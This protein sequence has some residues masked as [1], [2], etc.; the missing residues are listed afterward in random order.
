MTSRI[1]I[2]LAGKIGQSNWREEIVYGLQDQFTADYYSVHDMQEWPILPYGV[3]GTHDYTGPYFVSDSHHP[4]EDHGWVGEPGVPRYNPE[5]EALGA[6]GLTQIDRLQ[7]ADLCK[8]AIL[9]SDMVFAWIDSP[10]AYGTLVEIGFAV[11]AGIHTAVAFSPSVSYASRHDM[12]FADAA[13]GGSCF[14][15]DHSPRSALDQAIMFFLGRDYEL[16]RQ[17]RRGYV[18]LMQ[19][20]GTG[21]YKIGRSSDPA[22]RVAELNRAGTIGPFRILLLRQIKTEDMVASEQAL[23]SWFRG[24]R[25]QGE[26]FDLDSAQVQSLTEMTDV[27]LAYL[28]NR[29]R[30]V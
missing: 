19:A 10:D 9:Q 15:I 29:H 22:R 5:H 24:N 17:K 4:I 14:A 23:H 21:R 13:P 30:E 25:V 12:W 28:T 2:Y 16:D 6:S 26:W 7:I 8:K 3:L 11:G 1:K 18:Y 27:Q 20:E